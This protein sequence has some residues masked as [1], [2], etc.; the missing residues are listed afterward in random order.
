MIED[1]VNF[2]ITHTVPKAMSLSEIQQ[3]TKDD[4]TLHLIEMI[5]TNQWDT[6]A[7]R[8][9]EGVD[10]TELQS[11]GRIKDELTVSQDADPW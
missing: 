9:P 3:A 11:F 6:N 2:L 4:K 1:Y 10:L 5:S 7:N 8:T